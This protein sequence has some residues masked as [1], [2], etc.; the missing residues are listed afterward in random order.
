MSA[1]VITLLVTL[2]TY[3]LMWVG[4]LLA[5]RRRVHMTIMIS[6]VI[7]DL[8]LPIYL[9]LDRDWYG[10]LIAHHDILTFGVWMHFALVLSLYVLYVFQVIA[11][12]KILR[13]PHSAELRKE[14]RAQ[15]LGI[16]VVRGCVIFTGALLLDPQYER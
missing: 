9:Y 15:G 12:R 13:E 16:L 6:V 1:G 14:H 3:L 2:G 11:A 7:Y 5:G 10:R 4:F 8:C